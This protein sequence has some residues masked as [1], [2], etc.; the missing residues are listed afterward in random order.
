M[1]DTITAQFTLT[2][3][4]IAEGIAVASNTL[5]LPWQR[6]ASS[7]LLMVIS[8]LAGA[9]GM[10]IFLTCY[11]ATLGT[12]PPF[13]IAPLVFGVV[14]S[15]ALVHPGMVLGWMSTRALVFEAPAGTHMDL[16]ANGLH[17]WASQEDRRLKWPAVH[18]LTQGKTAIFLSI[19]GAS[20]VLPNRVLDDPRAAF[21][22]LQTWHKAAL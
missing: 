13:Y 17:I 2:K 5:L 15:L 22:L 12:Q 11:K 19:S 21:A 4:E 16:D 14:G 10:A 20:F 3:D 18:S 7:L 8:V 6:R 1:T 9:G